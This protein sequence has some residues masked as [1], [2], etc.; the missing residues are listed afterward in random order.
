ML[1]RVPLLDEQYWGEP[2]CRHVMMAPWN[3]PPPCWTSK[4]SGT[5]LWVSYPQ[6]P[7]LRSV[8]TNSETVAAQ[9]LRGLCSSPSDDVQI[10]SVYSSSPWPSRQGE[11]Q[12]LARVAFEYRSFFRIG[13]CVLWSFSRV[14]RRR[15]IAASS[16]PSLTAIRLAEIPAHSC[17]TSPWQ[18]M[19]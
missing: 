5:T 10:P 6:L 13:S 17:S 15:V 2:L 9:S 7:S 14:D 3:S 16:D 4:T 11:G 1:R 19:C 8:P 18:G 12:P